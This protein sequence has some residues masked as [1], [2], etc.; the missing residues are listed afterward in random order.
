MPSVA[1]FVERA[2]AQRPDYT[3]SEQQVPL[4]VQLTRQLDGLPLAIELAAANMNVLTLGAIAHYLKQHIQTL[5]WDAQDLPARQRSLQAAIGWSYE[6]LTEAEQRLFRHLGVFVGLV[7]LNAIDAVA[8]NADADLTL[9]GLAALA[10]KSLVLPGQPEEDD[11]EPA[12]VLLD[13]MRQF[14]CEQLEAQNELEAAGRAH[15][16]YF[17]SLAERAEPQ[18]RRRGQVAWCRRLESEHDNLRVA[19]RW[20]LDRGRIDRLVSDE[21]LRLAGALSHFWWLRGYHSE[22]SHWLEEALT[23]ASEAQ[24]DQ[25]AG[26]PGASPTPDESPSIRTKALL[27]AGLLVF[28]KGDF[29]RSRVLLEEALT[30]SRRHHDRSRVAQ[31]L[32]YLGARAS[33]SGSWTES[34]QLFQ[35]ALPQCE[36][37]QDDYQ[38]GLTLGYF[39]YLPFMQGE[40]QE[41]AALFSESKSR[42]E[43]VGEVADATI[44]QFYLAGALHQLGDVGPAVW[45]L[46]EGLERSRDLHDRWLLSLGVEALQLFVAEGAD[47]ARRARLVG[48]GDTLV[49][50]TG[51]MYGTFRRAPGQSV[52]GHRAQLEQEGFGA[53]YHQ[54]RSMPF[55]EVVALALDVLEHFAGTL[56][57]S[58]EVIPLPPPRESPMSPREQEVLRLVAEGQTSKQIGKQLFLSPRTVDHHLY[59]VFNKLGV[60]SRAQAVAVAARDGF[61]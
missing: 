32:T 9:A 8:G 11:P 41:S 49:Q 37:L 1:L 19:L 52:A 12:F 56:T 31:A 50:A 51:A 55:S 7:S 25:Q 57:R 44:V 54:G 5:S 58:E 24:A 46:H 13:T 27:G 48:A 53:D 42:F 21:A 61:L 35:E 34:R 39:A 23:L 26:A 22:G 14:A 33:S 38:M 17:L 45:H 47:A 20:L 18:L 6:L 30:L 4:L 40:Y 16:Q 29:E 60:E 43:A 2:Q 28:W 36:E 15:A 10:E 3:P 59:T